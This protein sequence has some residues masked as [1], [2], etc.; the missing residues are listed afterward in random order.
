MYKM[1]FIP[2]YKAFKIN[3]FSN[4]ENIHTSWLFLFQQVIDKFIVN[5][6]LLRQATVLNNFSFFKVFLFFIDE[7]IF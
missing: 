2:W 4:I 6:A 5:P 3:N 7:L 1:L